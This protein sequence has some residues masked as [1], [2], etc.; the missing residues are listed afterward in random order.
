VSLTDLD[1]LLAGGAP[2]RATGMLRLG[3]MPGGSAIDVPYTIVEPALGDQ[4]GNTDVRSD[5]PTRN[6]GG[7]PI[8]QAKARRRLD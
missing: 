6:I 7:D 4:R 3:E 8:S 2:R 5:D 1:G